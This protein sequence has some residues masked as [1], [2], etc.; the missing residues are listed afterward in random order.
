MPPI[1]T[2]LSASQ[3]RDRV[4]ILQNGESRSLTANDQERRKRLLAALR[5]ARKGRVG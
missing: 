1:S 3:L 2:A 4:L 5:D